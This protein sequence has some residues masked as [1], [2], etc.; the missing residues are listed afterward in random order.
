MKKRFCIYTAI[1]GDYDEIRQP[2]VVDDD[3]DYYLFSDNIKP[4]RIGV[5][6]VRPIGYENLNQTKIAR[7]VKTHPELFVKDYDASVW[8]DS[9]ILI[10]TDFVYQRVR[11]LFKENVLVSSMAHPDW[12]CT[13][14][15]M[16]HIMYLGWE[17]ERVTLAWGHFLRK[18][19]FPR[20]MGTFETGILYRVHLDSRVEAMDKR[21]WNCIDQYSRRDQFSFRYCL[22]KDNVG[23]QAFL[24]DGYSIKDNPYFMF[25][26]HKNNYSKN[27]NV[28]QKTKDGKTEDRSWLMRYYMKHADEKQRM[29]NVYYWIYGR[30]Q[31]WLWFQILG[32]YFR[33]R[34]L[35]LRVLGRKEVYMWEV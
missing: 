17:T 34:H 27:V 21:W 3:F 5:W 24:P 33:L 10:Q 29:E 7:Y 9:S 15:E 20:E 35:V 32:Q 31:Y 2:L 1:V 26:K 30:K 22:W 18:E 19:A 16:L 12:T 6:E 13:Y 8:I 4:Q 11:L 28:Y 23:I 25:F 14:Q